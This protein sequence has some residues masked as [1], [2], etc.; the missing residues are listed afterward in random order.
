M[1]TRA[2]YRH[3]AFQNVEQLRQLV[4]TRASKNATHSRDSWVVA[5]RLA[6]PALRVIES[7]HGSEFENLDRLVVKSVSRLPIQ[8]W[9]FGIEF[10]QDCNEIGRASC[11]E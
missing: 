4:D 10:Y 6:E 7:R 5:H 8:D 11:R 2:D 3:F 9:S 1:R